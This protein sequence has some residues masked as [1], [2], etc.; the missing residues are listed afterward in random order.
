MGSGALNSLPRH[1]FW[2]R[3]H[4][5]Q[6]HEITTTLPSARGLTGSGD[7]CG[8]GLATSRST[9]IEAIFA[10]SAASMEILRLMWNSGA[11]GYAPL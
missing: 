3:G 5:A 8:V 6:R 2:T 1:P 4:D 10:T 7:H 11:T 9:R